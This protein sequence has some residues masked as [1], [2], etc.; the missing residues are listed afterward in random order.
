MKAFLSSLRFRLVVLVVL[1]VLPALALILYTAAE[2]RRLA[3]TGIQQNA[4]RIARL[5]SA[6]QERMIEGARQL[7]VMM[8]RLPVIRGDDPAAASAILANLL[9][10]YSIYSN[11]GVIDMDGSVFA[12]GLPLPADVNL[13]DRSYFKRAV[14]TREFAM[15]D[16]QI[17][18]ITKKAGVNFGYPIIDDAG[19]VLRVVFAAL[20]LSW[21]EQLAAEAELPP[22]GT[23][24]VADGQGTILARWPD[25]EKWRGKS[26]AG[27]PIWQTIKEKSQGTT[28]AEGSTGATQLFAF[29]QL[30]GA[31]GAGFVSVNIGI[32]VEVAYAEANRILKRNLALLGIAVAMALAAAW[33]G[34]DWFVLRRINPLVAAA[35]RLE[36]GDLESRTGIRH[37]SSEVGRLA[38]A[39][40]G[41]AASLQQ[42]GAERDRAEAALTKL[43]RELEERVAERTLELR[44]K[45]EQLEADL[46]LASEFQL[47]L[48]PTKHPNFPAGGGQGRAT[49]SFCH[50][51]EASGAVSGDFF[52]ILPLTET[53]AAVAV[54]DV[55]G[56]GVRAALVTAIVRGLF[57]EFR[58]LA[59]DPGRFMT[60]INRELSTLLRGTETVMFVTGFYLVMDVACGRVSFAN[61]GHPWPLHLQRN[62]G[63]VVSL[64]NGHG[65][66]GA[67]LGLFDQSEY[68]TVDCPLA[69]GDS[70]L[71]FTDGMFEV[72]GPNDE[73]FGAERLVAEI[74][75]R[76]DL[77]TVRI[78]KEVV[79]EARGFSANRQ[80]DDDVCM[81][82][83]DLCAPASA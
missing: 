67:A 29:T 53:Q 55:M 17:G 77:P 64:R 56:H 59:L 66:P 27:Q 68:H 15:G 76:I 51:Y 35:N 34:G 79:A 38:H 69:A 50:M 8:T 49:L 83:V 3:A 60:E 75:K 7:L 82:G 12:S 57:E 44:E 46:L 45:N 9:E 25:P 58:P 13:A 72:M 63:R 18:R 61:A 62:A 28:Q 26:M 42:R 6:G 4:L 11:F 43:N 1:G 65:K 40:D 41:M 14:E 70:L 48:L 30:R 23:L 54:F 36:T 37:G 74:N 24:S 20:D 10:Q 21:I 31:E 47:A 5:A 2:Q 78:L 71:L 39:F 19:Q 22:G 32:P 80:F 52:E 33:F 16:Y 81:V 73:V